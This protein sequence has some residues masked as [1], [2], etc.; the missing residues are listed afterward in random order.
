MALV[1]KTPN[2]LLQIFFHYDVDMH[3]V[4]CDFVPWSSCPLRF[5]ELFV[6]AQCDLT[7]LKT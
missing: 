6:D 7:L 1:L 3:V 4:S 5:G 2:P